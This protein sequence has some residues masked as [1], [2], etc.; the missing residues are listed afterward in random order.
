M[1]YSPYKKN[2]GRSPKSNPRTL[3][4]ISKGKPLLY[5]HDF[6][7]GPGGFGSPTSSSPQG[8][9]GSFYCVTAGTLP[10]G[11]L[12]G[13]GLIYSSI[14]NLTNISKPFLKPL[15]SIFDILSIAIK[16]ADSGIK[17]L[18]LIMN[19]EGTDNLLKTCE[20]FDI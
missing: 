15:D 6:V 16:K 4:E 2:K 19:Y 14:F 10:C 11:Y 9:G 8:S 5:I 3:P 1:P 7:T 12:M 13:N 18:I 17:H 20:E